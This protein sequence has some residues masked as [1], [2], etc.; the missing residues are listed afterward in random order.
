MG[1]AGHLTNIVVVGLIE[2]A[3]KLFI[4][5]RAASKATWPNRYELIGGHVDPGETLESA[6]LREIDEEIHVTVSVDR[7]I[8][9]FTYESENTFKVEICYLCHL[10][11]DQ[12][13]VLNPFDH[14][15]SKWI[16][17]SEIGLFEKEDQETEVLRKTFTI[18]EGEI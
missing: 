6:L 15:E 10:S 4:A 1:D 7:I 13:P 5:K 9:A 2:R 11:S 16:D 18:I 3:G 17:K 8:E 12:E 14:S